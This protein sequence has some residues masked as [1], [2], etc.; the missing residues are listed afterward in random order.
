V[1]WPTAGCRRAQLASILVVGLVLFGVGAPARAAAA[2]TAAPLCSHDAFTN[3]RVVPSERD[4]AAGLRC[5]SP[6]SR[7]AI[8]ERP[9]PDGGQGSA[10]AGDR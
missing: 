9:T 4:C 7:E 3:A 6:G 5:L 8:E 2:P 10:P 1:I